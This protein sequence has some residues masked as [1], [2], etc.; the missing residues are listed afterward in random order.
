MF[1][2]YRESSKLEFFD[3]GRLALRAQKAL[4]KTSKTH[5][6]CDYVSGRLWKNIFAVKNIPPTSSVTAGS[7]SL[8]VWI[9]MK[10][11][12]TNRASR[13][14]MASVLCC[15]PARR[16]IVMGGVAAAPIPPS[17]A[18]G[19]PEEQMRYFLCRANAGQRLP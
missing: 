1:R 6:P 13:T 4:T 15:L 7:C 18:R 2:K 11:T 16:I 10:A 12:S 17:L 19:C 3:V 9:S 8:S 5:F 14:L